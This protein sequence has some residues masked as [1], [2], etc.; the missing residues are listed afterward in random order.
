MAKIR[1]YDTDGNAMAL[2]GFD[3]DNA[4]ELKQ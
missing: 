4:L 3:V 2:H 1:I